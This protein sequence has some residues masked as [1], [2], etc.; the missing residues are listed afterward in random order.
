[1]MKKKECPDVVNIPGFTVDELIQALE[2]LKPSLPDGG[3]TPVKFVDH[4]PLVR[5]GALFPNE[6]EASGFYSPWVFITDHLK[7]GQEETDEA[8]ARWQRERAEASASR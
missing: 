6:E 8:F 5:V 7:G 1:M 2:K 4:T 3:D